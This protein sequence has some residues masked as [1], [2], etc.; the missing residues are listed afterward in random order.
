MSR[1]PTMGGDMA[2]NDSEDPV[3]IVLVNAEDFLNAGVEMLFAPERT[4]RCAKAG[5]VLVQ[6]AIELMAKYR[7]IR[8]R[9][10]AVVIRG[11]LPSGD[12][13]KAARGGT[14]RTI[15]YGECLEI[16]S[17][18]EAF[19]EIEWDLVKR[20]QQLR[21]ALV[22]FAADFKL[23]EMRMDVAWLLIRAL[24]MFA[25]GEERDQGEMQTHGRFLEAAN[26]QTLINYPPYRQ[27]AV[28]AAFDSPESQDVQ[29]C[30]NCGVEALSIRSSD[31]YFCHCCGLTA[32]MSVASYANCVLCGAVKGICYDPLNT[33]GGA[34]RGRCLCCDASVSIFICSTCGTSQLKPNEGQMKLECSE[35][36]LG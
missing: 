12:L 25:A 36:T 26:F 5:I 15:G 4:V 32:D 20:V 27:E 14:L 34:Y 3:G 18:D 22:H 11:P 30:W 10:L 29:Y 23:D 31:T 35:C 8:E 7:L 2:I 19:T 6:T 24:A 33:T 21:N 1:G 13:L 16:I 28:D 9:G 17:R